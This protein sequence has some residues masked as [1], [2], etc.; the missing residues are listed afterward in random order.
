MVHKPSN[1]EGRSITAVAVAHTKWGAVQ[2]AEGHPMMVLR[3]WLYPRVQVA[4]QVAITVLGVAP[5]IGALVRSPTLTMV[6]LLAAIV[7][8]LSR[9]AMHVVTLPV[10]WDASFGKAM[11]VIIRGQFIAPDEIPAANVCCVP[12]RW[13]MCR[14]LADLSFWRW[15]ALLRGR[16]L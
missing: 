9:V 15:F 7:L 10:E 11:P 16:G 12:L 13:P 8:F 5:V 6:F 14:W 3:Q 2:H 1:F 4:E